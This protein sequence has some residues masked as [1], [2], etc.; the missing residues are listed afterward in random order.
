M[1]GRYMEPGCTVQLVEKTIFRAGHPDLAAG[2]AQ[3]VE[4]RSSSRRVE[5]RR[6]FVEQKHRRLAAISRHQSRMRQQDREQQRLLLAGRTERRRL[7]LG[8]VDDIQI[9]TM[10]PR[11]GAAGRGI[12]SPLAGKPLAERLV[13]G[14]IRKRA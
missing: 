13:A 2:F 14:T 10:R 8:D 5:M 12:T 6:H 4:Q 9:M 3:S 7:I 1:P 11:Q